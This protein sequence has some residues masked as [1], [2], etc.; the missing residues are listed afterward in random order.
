[1]FLEAGTFKITNGSIEDNI[2]GKDGGGVYL[3]AGDN[4]EMTAGS[5]TN[6]LANLKGGGVLIKAGKFTMKGGTITGNRA[7]GS[8]GGVYVAGGTFFLNSTASKTNINSNFYSVSA[9]NVG[10]ADGGEI[11]GDPTSDLEAADKTNGW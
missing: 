2:S 11:D 3:T 10:K 5:I 4:H 1:M 6:N 8:E 7:F 9:G